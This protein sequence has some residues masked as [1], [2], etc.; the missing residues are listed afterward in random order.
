[1]LRSRGSLR[2]KQPNAVIVAVRLYKSTLRRRPTCYAYVSGV[3]CLRHPL[4]GFGPSCSCQFLS[5][6]ILGSSS[7]RR[8]VTGE[9][10]GAPGREAGP[11]GGAGI[12]GVPGGQ[13]RQQA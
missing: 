1:M 11:V 6:R 12:G 2:V 13:E 5:K 8:R 7:S 9:R 10:G 4:R 3:E